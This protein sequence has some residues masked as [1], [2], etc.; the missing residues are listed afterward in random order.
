MASSWEG[1][2]LWQEMLALLQLRGKVK[3]VCLNK[4]CVA[5]VVSKQKL[6]LISVQCWLSGIT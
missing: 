3:A 6:S 5:F 4:G 1:E 2:A